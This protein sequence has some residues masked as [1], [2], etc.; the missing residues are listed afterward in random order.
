MYQVSVI[1]WHRLFSSAVY[2]LPS[3]CLLVYIVLRSLD[4]N[5][6]ILYSDGHIAANDVE[7]G[8]GAPRQARE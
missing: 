8:G 3:A 1:L 5:P 7:F 4:A 2:T 6:A